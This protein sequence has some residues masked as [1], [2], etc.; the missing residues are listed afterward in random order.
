MPIEPKYIFI[1]Q[2]DAPSEQAWC[3][4]AK[5]IKIESFNKDTKEYHNF[6]ENVAFSWAGEHNF[7]YTLGEMVFADKFDKNRWYDCTHGIHF[8]MK[9]EELEK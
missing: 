6:E 7:K 2:E 4:K 1:T 8:Y 5:V 3:S 9:K